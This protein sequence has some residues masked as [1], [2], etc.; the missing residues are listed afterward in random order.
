MSEQGTQI[1]PADDNIDAI[2]AEV[3]GT[4]GAHLAKRYSGD[5]ASIPA[6]P[7]Q[8]EPAAPVAAPVETPVAA[9]KNTA[10]T[11]PTPEQISEDYRS[12]AAR[13]EVNGYRISAPQAPYPVY[14][15]YAPYPA[16]PQPMAYP[17]YP[18]YPQ[19]VA[20]PAYPAYGQPYGYTQ[21]PTGYEYYGE[22]P[23]AQQ[24][25]QPEQP[26]Q[27]E[28]SPY[29]AAAGSRVVY[30]ADWA[31]GAPAAQPPAQQPPVQQPAQPS[32]P[33]LQQEASGKPYVN[34]AF[35]DPLSA[36]EDDG[37][38]SDVAF[39]DRKKSKAPQGGKPDFFPEGFSAAKNNA[40]VANGKTT[41]T[42][43]A[44]AD[45][46]QESA[47]AAFSDDYDKT[48][49]RQQTWMMTDEELQ[50]MREQKKQAS[51]QESVPVADE[52]EADVQDASVTA[53]S[54]P[55]TPE[56]EEA[57]QRRAEA[58]QIIAERFTP[59]DDPV[60]DDQPQDES[61]DG[62]LPVAEQF[63]T[64]QD[65]G[66]SDL[67]YNTPN[68]EEAPAVQ[69]EEVKKGGKFAAF[70][71]RNTPHKGQT[72]RE[73]ISCLIMDLA[74]VVLIGG[75]IFCGIYFGNYQKDINNDE[76]LGSIYEPDSIGNMSSVEL[77]D[78][79]SDIRAAYPDID[80]PEGLN[81]E[82]AKLYA[83]N[84][85]VVGWLSIDNLDLETVVLQANDNDY[86]L[87]RNTQKESTKY[88]TPFADYR[89][90]F[91]SG[92]LSRQTII[93]GHNT[94]DGLKFHNLT[95]YMKLEAYKKAP[96]IS[97]NTIFN[98]QT[99]WKIFAICL[100]DATSY[101]FDYLYT[102]FS[103]ESSFSSF[104]K[105]LRAH[106]MYDIDVDVQAGD[107]LL[108]LYTCYQNIYKNGRLLVFARQVRPGED[109]SVNTANA[110]VNRDCI[111][112][113]AYYGEEEEP[114]TTAI[115]PAT[116][117][118]PSTTNPSAGENATQAPQT[119]EPTAAPDTTGQ[120]PTDPPATEPPAD[121]PENTTADSGEQTP[122]AE[123]PAG[124]EQATEDNNSIG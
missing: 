5:G 100:S 67:Y 3:L 51:Q 71:R 64:T 6:K 28:T 77:D 55:L 48:V 18:V 58:E 43:S 33:V 19:P 102:S 54:I 88:G 101:E 122:P 50:A 8:E 16:Y 44:T 42:V 90:D 79:W 47:L 52:Q 37:G 109:A 22:Y 97:L 15:P 36:D 117:T 39:T 74:F 65:E 9:P 70:I 68:E 25:A 72:K 24:P 78:L 124:D 26:Q 116:T 32:V 69:A 81:P 118:K 59:Q 83:V 105:T 20:Y 84:Q 38:A 31:N 61:S 11:D 30:D 119:A 99:S 86:Y 82:M 114:S 66:E 95:Q 87:Y 29:A 45:S 62:F 27:T 73:F 112:P 115:I 49:G 104:V 106:S 75:L 12:A 13:Y 14:Q 108:L 46:E 96:V 60:P 1:P 111:Y 120:T 76:Q 4:E 94:H 17:T 2:L 103:S 121:E 40:A 57:A 7:K 113:A 35:I 110:T 107:N 23:P 91:E 10:P 92:T 93:Y 123:E 89:N 98:G 21:Y 34:P 56:E 53:D 63:D 80:F 85:D 41:P